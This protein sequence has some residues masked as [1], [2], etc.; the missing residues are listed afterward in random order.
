MTSRHTDVSK[1]GHGPC[2]VLFHADVD[3]EGKPLPKLSPLAAAVRLHRLWA[4]N[5]QSMQAIDKDYFRGGFSP[6][7]RH[8]R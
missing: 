3:G 5:H 8:A 6:N 4:I 1:R 7:M 2:R